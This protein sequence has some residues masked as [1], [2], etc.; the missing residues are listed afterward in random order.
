MSAHYFKYLFALVFCALF[1]SEKV[2]AQD[3][4]GSGFYQGGVFCPYDTRPARNAVSMSDDEREAR[5]GIQRA[6]NAL[7]QTQAKKKRAEQRVDSLRRKIDRYFDSSI[8]DFVLDVHI[9][10]AKLCS[11][12]QS[13]SNGCIVDPPAAGASATTVP[14]DCAAKETP[15]ELLQGRWTESRDG[16]GPYCVGNSR[17]SAGGVSGS[18]CDDDTLRPQ[19]GARRSYNTSQCKKDLADYRKLR[20]ELANSADEEERRQDEIQDREYAIADAR[21]QARIDREYRLANETESDCADCDAYSRGGG[22]APRMR[23]DWFSTATNVIGGLLYVGLGQRADSAGREHAAQLGVPSQVSYGY[24]YYQAGLNGIINGLSGPGAYGCSGGYGG[25]GFPFGAGGQFGLGGGPNGA[26]GPFAGQGGAF[27]Y[28]QGMFGSPWGGGAYNPG[29]NIYGGFNGPFGGTGGMGGFPGNGNMAM[30]FT[31]PCNVGGGGPQFGLGGGLGGQV[32]LG[33]GP[34]GGGPFGGGPFGGPGPQFGLGGQIGLGGGFGGP[35]GGG[36]FGGPFGG[37]PFGG[38]GQFGMNGQLSAQYQMQMAQLQMQ[39][40][41]QYQQQQMQ[42]YQQQMQV[43]MQYQQQQ[44]QRQQQAYQ[45]QMQMA[46]LNMQLQQL[47]YS[48]G[49]GTGGGLNLSGGLNFNLGLNGGFTGGVGA[50]SPTGFPGQQFPG[51]TPYPPAGYNPGFP[52]G[53]QFPPTGLPNPTT[54]PGTTTGGG[55]GR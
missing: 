55:R 24:P 34:F 13:R 37:G 46:Q 4:W 32:G 7:K 48:N 2:H 40:Q 11:S 5:Q 44:V 42:Y 41:Q 18:I 3:M 26:M 1:V 30:C 49:F 19:D 15:P 35:F 47:Y 27:G 20:I 51:G 6:R 50:P 14:Q 22:S 25:A 31:W 23:R 36:G 28:P 38:G 52:G 54:V 17:S 12:Y 45:I 21:E 33:G 10:G 39:M 43:Q 16:R 53:T 9:E 29:L 8:V